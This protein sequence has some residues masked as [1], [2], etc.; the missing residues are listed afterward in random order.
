MSHLT[1]VRSGRW[2]LHVARVA[3]RY[4]NYRAEPIAELYDLHADIG[5]TRDVAD[6]YPQVVDRLQSLAGVA[7]ADLGDGSTPGSNCRPPGFVPSA[8]TLTRN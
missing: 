3:G 1:G 2:K 7:R 4:P 6:A 5:E 8:T